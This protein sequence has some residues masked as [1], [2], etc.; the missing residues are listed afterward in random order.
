[1]ARLTRKNVPIIFPN[2]EMLMVEAV[3]T[4]DLEIVSFRFHSKEPS[5]QL[6]ADLLEEPEIIA[7]T[8]SPLPVRNIT[9]K[10]ERDI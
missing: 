7:M 6:L 10:K 2:A 4:R 5:A 1:M 3:I 8:F 9:E